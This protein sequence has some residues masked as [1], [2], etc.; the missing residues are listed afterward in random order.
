[1]I[2]DLR[3]VHPNSQI[4]VQSILPH[5]GE[6]AS[7]EGRDRLLAISNTQIR[8]LNRRLKEVA[9]SEN[10]LFLDLHPLFAD[11]D[12]NL[13]PELSTDGLHLN[14]QGYLVWRSALQLFSQLELDLAH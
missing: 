1:M 11:A 4:V 14:E 8:D 3:W 7:W 12:G 5:G 13:R 6:R 9:N 10:A 2:R